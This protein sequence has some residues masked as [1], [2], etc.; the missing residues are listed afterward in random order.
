MPAHPVGPI[1]PQSP[2]SFLSVL[3]NNPIS[4][5]Y[6]FTEIMSFLNVRANPCHLEGPKYFPKPDRLYIVWDYPLLCVIWE[7]C[8]SHAEG[9]SGS[10]LLSLPRCPGRLSR[11]TSPLTPPGDPTPRARGMEAE[12]V[13]GGQGG[14]GTGGAGER[15]AQTSSACSSPPCLGSPKRTGWDVGT[16][17][18]GCGP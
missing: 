5:L 11:P 12:L 8:L 18:E 4:G 15:G 14:G 10:W 9:M 13:E 1:R 16:M 6:H 17:W 2:C 7:L 3:E